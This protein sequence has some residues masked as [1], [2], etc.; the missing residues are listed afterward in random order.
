MPALNVGGSPAPKVRHPLSPVA[1]GRSRVLILGTMPSPRSRAEGFYY[2]HPGNRFWPVL[3]AL[4]AAPVPEGAA[5]R[6]AFV[7]DRRIALWDVLSECRIIGAADHTIRDPVP[8]PLPKLCARHDFRS[9]F[10]T[11]G[12]ARRYYRRFFGSDPGLPPCYPLPSTSGMNA[13]A[14]FDALVAAYRAILPFLDD[15]G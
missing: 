2:A 1:D 5:A 15:E 9:I 7:L 13:R 11:G 12:A 8:N 4:F 6:R 3:A 14:S 10:T